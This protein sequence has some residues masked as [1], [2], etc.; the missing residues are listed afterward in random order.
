MRTDASALIGNSV[1]LV[2][3]IYGGS[4]DGTTLI[5]GLDAGNSG[6]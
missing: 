3:Y 5:T 2:H 6:S 1:V 4:S